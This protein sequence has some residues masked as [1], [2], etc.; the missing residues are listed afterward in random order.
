MT[1]DRAV[2]DVFLHI[3]DE[4][5]KAGSAGMYDHVF[6][7]NGEVQGPVPMAGADDLDDAVQAARQAFSTWRAWRP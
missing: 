3:G 7:G 6:P 2:P 5:R 1:F 4:A